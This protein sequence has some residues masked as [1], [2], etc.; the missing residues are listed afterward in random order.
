MHPPHRRLG[1]QRKLNAELQAQVKELRTQLFKQKKL[2]RLSVGNLSILSAL[3][4]LSTLGTLNTETTTE[5]TTAPWSSEGSVRCSSLSG[6]QT[7]EP[8]DS[9]M[10]LQRLQREKIFRSAVNSRLSALRREGE[11]HRQRKRGK[12]TSSLPPRQPLH[13]LHTHSLSSSPS[14]SS[15]SASSSSTSGSMSTLSTALPPRATSPSSVRSPSSASSATLS[16]GDVD[17]VNVSALDPDSPYFSSLPRLVSHR[18]GS[19]VE[20]VECVV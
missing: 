19:L 8:V 3:N 16:T 1:E 10:R 5:T 15:S 14:L 7:R 6:L 11:S 4:P 9:F 13:P 12:R 2:M 20:C 17:G 18:V